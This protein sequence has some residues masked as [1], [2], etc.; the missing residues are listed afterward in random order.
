[1]PYRSSSFYYQINGP[2]LVDLVLPDLVDA[3]K[4][5][6]DT[7]GLILKWRPELP[8]KLTVRVVRANAR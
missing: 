5:K 6:A 2:D 1:M 7:D 8:Q 3:L 4:T